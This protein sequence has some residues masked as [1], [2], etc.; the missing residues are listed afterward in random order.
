MWDTAANFFVSGFVYPGILWNQVLL[1]IGLAVLFG[2]I[3]FTPYWT[4]ILK[5]SWAWAVLATSAFLGWIIVSFIQLPVQIWLG[6]GLTNIW[7]QEALSRW[8]MLAGIPQM[9]VS[10][11]VQEAVK[12]APVI[13]I[14]LRRDRSIS[15]RDGLFIG[16]IAGLGFGIF[17]AVY[18]HNLI[19]AQ[20]WIW[21]YVRAGGFLT[22][23]GFWERFFSIA[24]H[25]AVSALAGWGLAKGK[26]W[27]FYLIASL[28]HTLINYGIIIISAG[29]FTILQTEI[30]IAVIAV[31]L[32]GVMLWVRWK[33]SEDGGKI[34]VETG[35]D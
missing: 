30:Y 32:T 10:G 17:E 25:I 26:G 33:K 27:Q 14:W 19:L 8:L 16:A 5:K 29:Y 35:E 6:V 15:P 18:S 34:A 1:S 2:A 24:F 13:F 31:A 11:V 3:W 28:L 12:L 20:G 23:A 9:L 7:S 21:E 4:P 22:L